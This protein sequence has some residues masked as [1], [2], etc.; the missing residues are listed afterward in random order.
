MKTELVAVPSTHVAFVWLEVA[1]LLSP[2][3]EAANEMTIDFVYE[4]L[5]ERNLQLWVA[6]SRETG[7]IV[8]ALTTEIVV[9]QKRKAVRLMHVG[10]DDF[11]TWKDHL[12]WIGTWGLAQGATTIEAYCRPGVRKMLEENGFRKTME[13]IECDLKRRLQ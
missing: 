2:A 12:D 5:L 11:P 6:C 3:I 10:G 7:L 13:V 1:P 9:Y 8:A 4:Q